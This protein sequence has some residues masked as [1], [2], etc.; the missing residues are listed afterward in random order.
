MTGNSWTELEEQEVLPGIRR[1]SI[2]G[3]ASTITRYIYEPGSI[4]PAHTHPEEQITIVHQGAIEFE[5]DGEITTLR[6]GELAIIP[7]G[8]V[9]GARVIGD[10]TVISDNYLP[11]GSRTPMQVSEQR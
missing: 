11:T 9:H 7:G 3:T 8:A 4:F 10:E 2:S 1:R 6:A 5:I